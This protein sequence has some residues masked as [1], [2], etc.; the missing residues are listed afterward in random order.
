MLGRSSWYAHDYS[1]EELVEVAR[2]VYV[3]FN[4]DHWMLGNARTMLKLLR[5]LLV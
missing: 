2:R 5:E 4:N 1:Y 3:F